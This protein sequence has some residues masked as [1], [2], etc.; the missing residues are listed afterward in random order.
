MANETSL[1]KVQ[2]QFMQ[3]NGSSTAPLDVAR[4]LIVTLWRHELTTGGVIMARVPGWLLT[5]LGGTQE[6]VPSVGQWSM[7]DG[8]WSMVGGGQQHESTKLKASHC[9]LSAAA[10]DNGNGNGN[11]NDNQKMAGA[12]V[13]DG[14]IG[15]T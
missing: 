15:T 4:R 1:R 14:K 7:V 5:Y 6:C 8:R 11:G 3:C 12:R 9:R 13:R 2:D 10:D